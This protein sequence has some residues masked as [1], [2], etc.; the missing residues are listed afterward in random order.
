MH[1]HHHGHHHGPDGADV[2]E[3]RLLL[4]VLLNLVITVAEVIGGLVSGSL[5]L[6]S[7][8]VH[9]FGDTASLGISL[10]AR[11][12]GRRGPTPAKT[13]GYRRAE[14]I[15]AFI[16][17]VALVFIGLFLVKEAV[18]RLLDPQPVDGPVMLIVATIG[19]LANLIT[20][21][22]LFRHREGSLNIRSAFL[23]IVTDAVSSVG[24]VAG[25]VLI[26][27][28]DIRWIDPALTLVMAL[29]ILYH[30]IVM[31]RQTIDILMEGTPAEIDLDAIV[32]AVQAL[33]GVRDLHHLHVWHLDETHYALEAHVV[34][35]RA[36]LAEMEGIKRCI[37]QTLH[38]SF[39]I[40]HA[41]LEFEFDPC[42]QAGSVGC[43]P[44]RHADHRGVLGPGVKASEA[45]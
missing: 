2:S 45:P 4:S 13:F 31:L 9:N 18:E 8:A 3:R 44:D 27:L 39:H 43:G 1:T 19:L 34:I 10:A 5:A 32:E 14:V 38:D 11:R 21:L 25:G 15:G 33:P 24:V 29:Y 20:A 23:H 6:L 42:R 40:A 41:T 22:L 28:Y 30:G 12:I 7:D 16:N 36:D 26:L 37:K 35:D 17:L